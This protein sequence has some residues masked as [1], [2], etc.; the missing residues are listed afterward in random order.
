MEN[1]ERFN[2]V[3]PGATV[4]KFISSVWRRKY[5]INDIIRQ[6]IDIF[7][8]LS[9]ELP[10]GIKKSGIKSIVT[11]HDL[12]FLRYP[13]FYSWIDTKIYYW[14]LVHA[15]KVSDSIIAISKQTKSDLVRFLNISPDK[16]SVIYQGCNSGFWD[17][18]SDEF[19]RQVRTKYGLPDKYL[20]YV[21]TIEERKNLLG[22]VKAV[23][24]KNIKYPVVVIGR[25]VELYYR[26]VQDYVKAHNLDNFIF[27][28]DILNI[29]LPVIYQNAVCFIY[30][31]F[32]EG[33]GIPLLEALI[34]RTPVITSKGGCF[35]EAAGP[36][37]MYIDP[38]NPEEIGEA[39]LKV[40]DSKD[41]REKMI[42]EGSEYVNKFRDE[43]ITDSYLKLCH[44]L[45]TQNGSVNIVC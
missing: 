11:V 37:S 3:Q 39:I 41:L 1:E 2:I 42:N 17:N 7:H 44:S 27:L 29:E 10:A 8:G 38:Y 22:I 33:F 14:K 19:H 12:I 32:F 23:H 35:A 34:S 20:L 45:L 30:P 36:G 15:C 43:I 40:I 5:M 4:F 28:Q 13:E 25:K 16:I 21:G 31:S 9:Q 24:L 18:Y 26:M 6:K